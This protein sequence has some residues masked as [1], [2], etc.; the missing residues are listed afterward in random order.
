VTP[1][2]V[3]TVARTREEAAGLAVEPLVVLEDVADALGRP[4]A[5][6]TARAIAAG[7]SNFSFLVG[8]GAAR[9]VLRRPP[10]PPYPPSTHDVLREYEIL[11]ACAGTDVRV[12]TPVAAVGDPAV[13]GAPFYL[14]DH[15]DGEVL[16]TALPL[17]LDAARDGRAIGDELVDALAEIHALGR[18]TPGL[19]ELYRG[20]DYPARQ[21]RRFGGLWEQYEARP[22]PLVGEVGARLAARRPPP[23]EPSLVHGD[24]RLGNVM[25]ARSAPARLL[26]VL[27]WEMAALGDPLADLGYLLATWAEPG[28][29][30]GPLLELGAVTAQPGFPSRE[31]LATRYADRTGRSLEW[32]PWFE[33]LACWKSAVLLEGSYQR[34]VRGEADDP[35]FA[36]L[37]TGV[38]ELAAQASAALAR[39]AA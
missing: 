13:V 20:D 32:L 34:F 2:T 9:Y 37:E 6:V 33:A 21:L 14:M 38:P 31:D 1:A 28:D 36:R 11:R 26:A 8:D 18:H 4:G 12:P 16:T 19:E 17:G 22:L 35:F 5:T 15:V 23:V 27:D 30:T 7:N 10:R 3:T 25:F 29:A 39:L 24:Y